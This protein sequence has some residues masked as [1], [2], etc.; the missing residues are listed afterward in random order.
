M[1]FKQYYLDCLAHASYLIGDNDSRIAA[2]VD[3]QRDIDQYLR[4]AEEQN[5]KI[6]YV[7]LTHFHADFVAGHLELRN[8][9]GADIGLGA[10]A[11]PDYPFRAMTDG[12]EIE[13]GSVLLKILETPGHTPES[14]SILVYDLTQCQDKPYAILTGDT[15]FVGDVG[16][17]DL[18]ASKGITAHELAGQLYD[19]LHEK[20]LPLPDETLIYPAH[21]AGSLCGKNLSAQNF[22]TMGEQRRYNYALQPMSK[23]E[24]IRRVTDNQPEAPKYFAYD[25]SLN[26]REH[27]LLDQAL[28]RELRPLSLDE[29]LEL[30]STGAQVIDV[31]DPADFAGGHLNGSLNIG[32]GG[33]FSAWAGII[34]NPEH[35][36]VIIADPGR[37]KEA[38]IGL[39][40]IGFNHIAGYFKGGMQGLKPTPELVR[41]TNQ[42]TAMR[43]ADQLMAPSRPHLLDVRTEQE[44][45]ARGI[46]DS[47]NIPLPHLEKK[48]RNIPVDRNV[49]V[50]CSSGYR[51]SIAVSLLER[52]GFNN[53]LELAGGFDA[54][55]QA[56]VNPA[57]QSSEALQQAGG[58]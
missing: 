45:R 27:P 9:T 43:L 51:S 22:S 32:L 37:E 20:L 41:H 14:I 42:I 31:R 38:V 39:S 33:K 25:A 34:L 23:D 7:F 44:W 19:S 49:I 29:L 58:R 52:H 11:N 1:I 18:M 54:W 8:Q 55:E 30:K 26:R 48:L 24:F 4:D 56:V 46:D 15:L 28:E 5:L 16:R 40:R 3:P 17:P 2:I 47:H 50:F 21:G 53:I 57:I 6:R 13:F 35:S 10:R 36:I 12:Y